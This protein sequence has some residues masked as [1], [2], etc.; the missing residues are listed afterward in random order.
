MKRQSD[1]KLQ[2]IHFCFAKKKDLEFT[3]LVYQQCHVKKLKS[4]LYAPGMAAM[5]GQSSSS[6][7][8]GLE[9]L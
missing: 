9:I 2:V 4:L 5:L 1:N 8:L 6:L 7:C 3:Y